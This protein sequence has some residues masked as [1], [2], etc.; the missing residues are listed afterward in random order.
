MKATGLPVPDEEYEVRYYDAADELRQSETG[1][2]SSNGELLSQILPS[3][4]EGSAVAGKWYA[5]LWNEPPATKPLATAKFNVQ[6]S[7]IP[8]F[9]TVA[10]GIG[11][12]VLC[13]VIFLWMRKRAK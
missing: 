1:I 5:E 3:N 8:E 12:A 9:P 6:E 4:F 10:S 2:M 11:V 7:A 13:G